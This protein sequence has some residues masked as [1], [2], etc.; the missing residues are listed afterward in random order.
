MVKSNK[1]THYGHIQNRLTFD[2]AFAHVT[3]HPNTVY[4]TSGNHTPFIARAAT[5]TKGERKGRR[6]IRVLS[7]AER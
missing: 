3:A 6:V 2:E 1:G 5:V 7:H 4:Q